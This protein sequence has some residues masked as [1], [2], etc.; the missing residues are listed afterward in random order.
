VR[1]EESS[2]AARQIRRNALYRDEQ[3]SDSNWLNEA[4]ERFGRWLEKL[5]GNRRAN[6]N[7]NLPVANGLQWFTN[8]VWAI[9]GIGIA[10]FG[11]LAV[12]FFVRRG[13]VTRKSKAVLD[14]DEPVRTLDE[15]L[16]EADELERQGRHREAVRALYLACLLRFD[17]HGVARFERSETNW[18]HLRR[19]SASPNLPDAI[20]FRPTTQR[21]D[22]VWYGFRGEGQPDV[23]KFRAWYV[24]I[25]R[26]LE[27]RR[28]T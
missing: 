10:V 6:V 27:E 22:L 14:D 3:R 9:L 11:F 23:A 18:E 13:R 17:Q 16:A 1:D 2:N 12:R 7:P 19:I 21:F 5:F 8:L 4:L 15:W 24:E 26:A 20:D 25:V 28:G